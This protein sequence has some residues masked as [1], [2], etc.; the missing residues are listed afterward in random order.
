[1]IVLLARSATPQL[2]LIDTK[3]LNQKLELSESDI[4]KIFVDKEKG[5][6]EEV[7]RVGEISYRYDS[8]GYIPLNVTRPLFFLEK[9]EING[10]NSWI[11]IKNKGKFT[12]SALIT[13][14]FPDIDPKEASSKV[15]FTADIPTV[16]YYPPGS[17]V[18]KNGGDKIVTKYPMIEV[19]KAPFQ[20]YHS[21]KL[22]LF[23]SE[24]PGRIYV[25]IVYKYRGGTYNWPEK[26]GVDKSIILYKTQQGFMAYE[27]KP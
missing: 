15:G 9:V 10:E 23:L 22:P 13:I 6:I 18:Y 3:N 24:N 25:R 11:I 17:L 8:F 19:E 4:D 5:R 7:L 20:N 1:H 14:G 12:T 2:W 16:K 27:F 26:T 21:M